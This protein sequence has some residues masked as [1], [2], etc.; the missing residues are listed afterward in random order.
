MVFARAHR[1]LRAIG[2]EPFQVE[3]ELVQVKR[4]RLCAHSPRRLQRHILREQHGFAAIGKRLIKRAPDLITL[5]DQ[6]PIKDFGKLRS[7]IGA[8]FLS[9]RHV[10]CVCRGNQEIVE[11][12]CIGDGQW[13]PRIIFIAVDIVR[14]NAVTTPCLTAPKPEVLR[15]SLANR[16]HHAKAR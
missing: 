5:L 7:E 4:A 14:F 11:I 9:N 16:D 2:S 6:C 3:R 13:K 8:A 1:A 12:D 10:P 15:S